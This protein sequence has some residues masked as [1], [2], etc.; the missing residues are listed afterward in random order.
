MCVNNNNRETST[1]LGK[2]TH[3]GKHLFNDVHNKYGINEEIKTGPTAMGYGPKRP[4]I[5][6]FHIFYS[7]G[8]L[9]VLK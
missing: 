7:T 6:K 5:S 1:N 2:K 3:D 8:Y 4:V 9:L